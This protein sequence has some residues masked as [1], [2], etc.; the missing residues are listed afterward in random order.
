MF[1][2]KIVLLTYCS[3]AITQSDISPCGCTGG[4]ALT[5]QNCDPDMRRG[6]GPPPGSQTGSQTGSQRHLLNPMCRGAFP[7]PPAATAPAPAVPGSQQRQPPIPPSRTCWAKASQ[8][9][10]GGRGVITA[11]CPPSL[12][13]LP[14]L[15]PV[16]GMTVR[17]VRVR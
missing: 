16:R 1:E 3:Q 15:D 2:I 9:H 12:P 7:D 17:P 14:E 10:L 13:W 11:V 6:G 5:R 8:R 4:H